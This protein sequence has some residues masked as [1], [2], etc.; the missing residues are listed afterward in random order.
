MEVFQVSTKV[1]PISMTGGGLAL[2]NKGVNT[3]PE[4]VPVWPTI[5]YISDIGQYRGTVSGLRYF[6]YLIYIYTHTKSL[7]TIK[8]YLKNLYLP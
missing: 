2:Q 5:R 7:F 1:C 8:H 6:I 3:V 4:A